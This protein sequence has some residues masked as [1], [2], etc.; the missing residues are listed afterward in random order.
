MIWELDVSEQVITFLYS[1]AFGAAL[2]LIY[3]ILRGM[4]RAGIG[5]SKWAVFFADL[6]FWIASAWLVFCFMLVR[7]VGSVRSYVLLGL[8]VGA[9]LFNIL[10]SN[11]VVG[12]IA[13]ICS[14]FLRVY[15]FVEAKI[16]F[17]AGKAYVCAK[18]FYKTRL[19]HKKT[20]ETAL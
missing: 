16:R 12:V 8:A 19:K 18:K 17:F 6:L 14:L 7:T 10:L 5:R 13:V 3:D 20:L 1:I 9:G 15:H 4:R 11:L 2:C